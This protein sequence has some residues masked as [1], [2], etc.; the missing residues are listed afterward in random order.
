LERCLTELEERPR[1]GELLADIFRSVHTIKGTTGFLGY[2]RL[3]SLS[4]AGENLPG[5]LRDGKLLATAEIINALLD[6]MDGLR[7]ILRSIEL[8]GDEGKGSDHAVIERLHALQR[9]ET[10]PEE[11]G[12]ILADPTGHSSETQAAKRVTLLEKASLP[13]HE[14][15]A[16]QIRAQPQ[17]SATD[18][19]L[20]VDIELLNQ[21]M[22]LVGELVLT[23]NQILQTN[24]ADAGFTPLAR[25]LDM[26]TAGLRET[27]M[28]ARMQPVSQVFS[29]FPRLVRDLWQQ[30]DKRVGLQLEGQGS[31][32]DKSLLEAIQAPLTHSV[33]NA[34]FL[35]VALAWT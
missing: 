11:S 24:G 34:T 26:V 28:K 6:L 16:G 13:A 12:Q 17:V 33:R 4:H 8:A 20:R 30:L 19:T 21:M 1:D 9:T 10:T 23:R 27:V 31:E 7:V 3:E 32:L 29:K 18:S 25:R 14:P 15:A 5:L 35:D 2:S 22:N